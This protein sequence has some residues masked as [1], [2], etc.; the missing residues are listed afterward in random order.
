M[1]ATSMGGLR[2][3]GKC[4]AIAFLAIAMA[5]WAGSA[6]AATPVTPAIQATPALPQPQT[7]ATRQIDGQAQ[8]PSSSQVCASATTA[9]ATRLIVAARSA[10]IGSLT[11]KS[12]VLSG[13]APTDVVFSRPASAV[14][15]A[16]TLDFHAFLAA[17]TENLANL[18]VLQVLKV[19]HPPDPSQLPNDGSQTST[20]PNDFGLNLF[21]PDQSS[22]WLRSP[23]WL[24][25]VACDRASGP[26][27]WA[28]R[29]IS[30]SSRFSSA[31]VGLGLM[32]GLYLASGTWVWAKR[33]GQSRQAESMVPVPPLRTTTVQ[34]WPWWRCLDPV[35]M[36]SDNFDRASLAKLQ[37]FFFVMLVGFG[38]TYSLVR[39]GTL[40]DLSD[41]I[42]FLLGVSAFGALGNQVASVTRDRL[43]LDN[44][45]WLVSQGVIPLNDPGQGEPRWVDLVMS[46]SELNLYKLQALTFTLIVGA[47]MVTSGFSDLAKFTVPQ[48]M[49]QILG[50]SQFV[51]VG[52][53]LAKPANIGDLDD[54][55]TELRKRIAQLR[56]AANAGID[57]DSTGAMIRPPDPANPVPGAPANAMAAARALVPHAVS[58]YQE[59][60][61]EVKILVE[62]LSHRDMNPGALD[63]P[64]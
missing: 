56:V 62:S 25:V 60:V 5:A 16:D 15:S 20:T 49:L 11:R 28:E 37:I 27:A 45:A 47:A 23:R 22:Y 44:W 21:I 36:T 26:V 34:A 13:Q 14:G 7:A 54:L 17:D 31:L 10:P 50:L 32:G 1:S 6:W 51:F 52:G 24:V 29:Q 30:V 58:R 33:S 38:V 2:S 43:S 64:F 18:S 63:N 57:V 61:S 19:Q 40:S 48:T 53:Q 59:I 35:V 9:Q 42:V 55:L 41:S 8:A 46:D 39:T 12:D 4:S 3:M